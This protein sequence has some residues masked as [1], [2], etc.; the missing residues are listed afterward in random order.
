MGTRLFG[1]GTTLRGDAATLF[2]SPAI[3]S[4]SGAI[5]FFSPAVLSGSRTISENFPA[6]LRRQFPTAK[7]FLPR[8]NHLII[9]LPF[10]KKPGRENSYTHGKA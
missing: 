3:V 9:C 10:T 6:T 5:S 1:F 4:G 8:K 7:I 2:F